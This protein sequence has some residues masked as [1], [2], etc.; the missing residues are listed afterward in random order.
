M[1]PVPRDA[2]LPLSFS[3][4]RLWF[5]DQ[6]IPNSSTYNM[7]GIMRLTGPLDVTAF[8]RA[9]DEIVRRHEVLRTTFTSVD[10]R[11]VQVISED[12]ACNLQVVDLQE[13]P[14]AERESEAR[15]LAAA[16]AGQSF[17]L[18]RDPLMRAK[19]LRLSE[20]EHIFLRTVHHI[21]SDG[22]STGILNRELSALYKAFVTRKPY[23]LPEL[24]IQYVDFAVWQ[25]KWF[26]GETLEAQLSYWKQQLAEASPVLELPTDAL[27]LSI[28]TDRGERQSLMLSEPLTDALKALSRQENATLFMTLL[29]AFKILLNRLTGQKNIV[30]GSPIA[31]RNYLQTEDLIGFFIN[32]L[33]LHTDLSGNPDFRGLLKR[34][35]EVCLGAYEHQDMP[36]EKLVKELQSERNLSRTPL[37][38][39]WFNMLNLKDS[40]LELHDL[41]IDPFLVPESLARFALTV[42]V[43]EQNNGIQVSMVYSTDLFKPD[44]ISEMLEQYQYLLEQIATVP[45]K[46][47]RSYSLVTSRA[48]P[49]LPDPRAAIPEPEHEPITNMFTTWANRTPERPAVY[50]DNQTWTYG[51]LNESVRNLALGLLTCGVAPGDVVAISGRR[52]FGLIAS[53]MG[54]LMSRGVMLNLDRDLP[55]YRQQVMLNEARVG[56]LLYV[57]VQQ[58]EDEWM[59][60]SL[61]VI[62][63]DADTGQIMD[64][65]K[66]AQM[67]AMQL[68][69]VSPEDAA[70]VFFTSGTTGV[71]KGI[72]GCHKGLSHLLNWHRQV[73]A[74]E[75]SDR[76]AQLMSISFDAVMRDI[77]LP[78]TSGATLC[79]P[80]GEDNIVDNRILAWL[81]HKQISI[82]HV[83]PSVAQSWLVDVPPGISLRA[84]RCV[85]FTGEPLTQTLVHRWREAF[86]VSGEIINLYGPT[87][88]TLNKC[89]YRVPDEPR[90]GVQP[91][92]WPVP[93]TQALVL[94][95]D[96]QMCGIGEPG[97]IVLRT[98]FRTLG[99]INAS[100]GNQRCFVKNPF[101]DDEQDRLYYTGDGGRYLPDGCLEILGRLDDQV[102][103]RG[104]RIEPGEIKSLLD[105]HPSVS[106]TA[107]IA[108]DDIS[109]DKCL[110]AY[111]VLDEDH[112]AKINEL[113]HFLRQKLPEYMVPSFFVR[114]DT[115]PLMP[116]GKVDRR[117]LP[118]P[119]VTKLDLEE[120]F[121]AP[122]TPVEQQIADIWVAVLHLEQVGIHNNFFELGGHSL[123]ATQ[124]ISRL[125]K[126]FQIEIP[127]RILFEMPTVA[128]LADF[129]AV[130]R[131]GTQSQQITP[132]DIGERQERGIL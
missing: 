8:E 40:Q 65:K 84:S 44:R 41:I 75:Q 46:P 27:G 6:L 126:A 123:L 112:T 128:G 121:V 111:I 94:S 19:L 114:L 132:E 57:G 55:S 81:E 130:L 39:V 89:Y 79:L 125:R 72:L 37:F 101:R 56:Y 38:Q 87:E 35:R 98:P 32:S 60:E 16:E 67:E 20:R 92:G 54:V 2:E 62:H 106:R 80:S 26:Q 64:P 61:T 107:V 71:P 1:L 21:A 4:Q 68:P 82:F 15:R 88:T 13:L 48:L 85:F 131:M 76:C 120:T 127:L 83:V 117:A 105:Q 99:Y 90:P 70:Y 115:L 10:G 69:E 53:M 24:P 58:P 96:N 103:I 17:D 124:V 12:I 86:P 77:F 49:L 116:N 47:I 97:E 18:S 43:T 3:Q 45:E 52:S 100:E 28:Q 31:G 23:S 9:L 7:P 63:I 118:A 59:W 78:L 30:V 11:P 119:D 122:R 42:Y 34:V 74:V 113:R 25:R 50:Q 129:I 14:E 33:V 102:K 93:E 73:S 91:V 5:L 66:N 104:V 51:E 95:T 29:S 110:V 36:F 108:R 109:D 22:W